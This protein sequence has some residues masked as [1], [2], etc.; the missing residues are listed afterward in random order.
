MMTKKINGGFIG[1]EDRLKH[2]NHAVD[3]LQG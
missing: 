1:L 3:I 2:Y